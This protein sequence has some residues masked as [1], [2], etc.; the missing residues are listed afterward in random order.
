M[1]P[2]FYFSSNNVFVDL[3]FTPLYSTVIRISGYVDL[4]VVSPNHLLVTGIV[5]YSI[6]VIVPCVRLGFFPFGHFSMMFSL[7]RVAVFVVESI[8]FVAV[9]AISIELDSISIN[10]L[11]IYFSII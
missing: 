7:S 3:L 11:K 8:S 9:I 5:R 2:F 6:L 4:L 1:C 10:S